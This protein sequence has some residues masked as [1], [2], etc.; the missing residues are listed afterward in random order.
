MNYPEDSVNNHPDAEGLAEGHGWGAPDDDG[1]MPENV[2]RLAGFIVGHRIVSVEENET[3]NLGPDR[4][5]DSYY[6]DD[7]LN[8]RLVLTLDNGV[9]VGIGETSDCCARTIVDKFLLHPERVDHVI[10]GVASTDG[11]TKW[12]I[13]AD[14]GDVME[15]DVDW[16]A[17]NPFYYGYGFD[18]EVAPLDVDFTDDQKA[19]Q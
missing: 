10:T 15:L 4:G 18:I 9:R 8:A 1:T 3:I 7:R 2:E 6:Y 12:H 13:F 19:I 5:R 11:Y 14:L 17:G 16:S